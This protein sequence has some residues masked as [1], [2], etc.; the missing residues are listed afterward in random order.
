GEGSR[1]GVAMN[2]GAVERRG[3]LDVR[4]MKRRVKSVKRPVAKFVIGQL[5]F[6]E[7]RVFIDDDE[8]SGGRSGA[9]SVVNQSGREHLFRG[10]QIGHFAHVFAGGGG[11]TPTT[12]PET[13]QR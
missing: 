10:E 4:Q 6:L 5:D 9:E 8:G 2:Y 11:C 12:A 3:N 7:R 1:G 13:P